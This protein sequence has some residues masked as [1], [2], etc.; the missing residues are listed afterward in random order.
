MIVQINPSPASFHLSN[1]PPIVS[2]ILFLMI[3]S[4]SCQE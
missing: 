4:F 2:F 1:Q 3:T